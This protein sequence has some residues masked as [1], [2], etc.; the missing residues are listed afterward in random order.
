MLNA[1]Y[2]PAEAVVEAKKIGSWGTTIGI[3]ALT[4]VLGLLAAVITMRS[5]AGLVVGAGF[6]LG[7]VIFAFLGGL[8][9]KTGLSILGAKNPG[10]FE[11]VSTLV[12]SWAPIASAAFVSSII[13]L[14]PVIGF[15]IAGIVMALGGIAMAATQIRA[16]IELMHTDLLMSVVASWII[17]SIGISIGYMVSIASFMTGMR[18]YGPGMF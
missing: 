9:L 11:A 14:I 16:I 7:F 4:G 3:L 12:Y 15:A 8:F 13:A 6:F 5:V 2:N 10:Y 18:V 17:M 1:F